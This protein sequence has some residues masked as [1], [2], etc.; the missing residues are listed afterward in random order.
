MILLEEN[1]EKKLLDINF[2]S[3]ITKAKVTSAK[4]SKWNYIT[5][6]QSQRNEHEKATYRMRNKIFA[7][8][9]SDK[10]LI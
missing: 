2:L 3:M 1:I 5:L 7:S 4:V 9:I 10:G 8:H 6:L